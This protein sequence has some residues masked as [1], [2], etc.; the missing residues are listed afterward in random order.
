MSPGQ[1]DGVWGFDGSHGVSSGYGG[2]VAGGGLFDANNV[3]AQIP[4]YRENGNQDGAGM[5]NPFLVG[6]VANGQPVSNVFNPPPPGHH[7]T[8]PFL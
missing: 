8:N 2:G 7:P 4:A 5:T 6:S 3:W 1:R